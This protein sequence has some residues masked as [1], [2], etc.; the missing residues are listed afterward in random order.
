M[1]D[2]LWLLYV[3]TH[4]VSA[5]L[6][7]GL[8]YVTVVR[9]EMRSKRLFGALM[10]GL[11]LWSLVA[12]GE[13]VLAGRTAQS[14]TKILYLVVG[15]S[16]PLLW[17]LFTA[18]YTHRSTHTNPVVRVFCAVYVLL[19][20]TVLTNPFHQYYVSLTYHQTPFPHTGI[21]SGPA[22]ILGVTYTLTGTGLGTYYLT[23]LFERGR[24]QVSTPTAI[25]AGVVLLGAVPFLGSILGFVP[26]S[27]YEHTPFGVSVFL[28]GVGYV[29]L[30]YDFYDLSPIARDIIID[31][32]DDAMFILDD[33]SRLVDHNTAAADVV[34]E[35]AAKK[36]GTPFSE[37]HS[38]LAT[39]VAELQADQERE[40]T[41]QAS[42]EIR[43]FSV[44]ASDIVRSSDSIGTVVFLRDVTERKEYQRAVEQTRQELRQVVDLIPD[45]IFVKNEQDEL[46]LVNE[47]NAELVGSTREEIE[48]EPEPALFPDVDHYETL[49]QRDIEVIN[50]GES[51][52]FEEELT[53]ADGETHVFQTTRI[54]FE[55]AKTDED[56]VLGYARDVTDLKKYEQDLK[57]QR[58]SLELLNQV[59][60]HDIRNKLQVVQGYA[61]VLQARNKGDDGEYAEQMREAARDAVEITT[62]ARDVTE[63]MLQ[64]EVDNHGVRLAPVLE[65]EIENA[66]S[67]HDHAL[68]RVD[69]PLP[70]VDVLADDMLES[71]FRNLLTNAVRHNGKEVPEVTVSTDRDGGNVL[72]RIADNGP[73]IPDERRGEIFEQGEMGIDS[74]GTGLGLYL[75]EILVDRYG[76]E[77]RV[78]DN[79]PDGVV[80]A[81]EL[82]VAQD[83]SLQTPPI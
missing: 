81:V 56:A 48:G 47:A 63:M 20:V 57:E 12:A 4:V 8:G 75:V 68:V 54:P 82:P 34:P 49:R 52:V 50:S 17:V 76:G 2:N 11:S 39:T 45:P 7:G 72:V 38:E 79:D 26:V 33:K 29:V 41:L 37:L 58:D 3:G 22:R 25:L 44:Q 46:L 64:D 36:A 43:H 77:V 61:D 83:A 27:T 74:D 62:T 67:T 69:R 5:L 28:L 23:S 70:D 14:V 21:T 24:S 65:G 60:R 30:W 19:L 6:A 10:L 31:E 73:G 53:S 13:L 66:R 32:I 18:D 71:V 40:I 1:S 15:L 42:G 9:T 78:E 16:V 59:V 35:L 80:F 55:T 51:T